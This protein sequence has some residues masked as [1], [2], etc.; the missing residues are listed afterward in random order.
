MITIYFT[1]NF[2]E[3][4]VN[5][6]GIYREISITYPP[7]TPYHPP[8]PTLD[9]HIVTEIL[10][11]GVWVRNICVIVQGYRLEIEQVNTIL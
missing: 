4:L 3:I 10:R 11:Y 7:P 6:S 9:I 1:E 8:L 5:L 2:T